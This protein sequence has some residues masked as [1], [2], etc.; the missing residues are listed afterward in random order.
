MKWSKRRKANVNASHHLIPNVKKLNYIKNPECHDSVLK[1]FTSCVLSH[2]TPQV[3][4][5]SHWV[6]TL[7][8]RGHDIC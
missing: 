6:T 3:T 1:M 7:W 8:N 4:H 5:H 2:T